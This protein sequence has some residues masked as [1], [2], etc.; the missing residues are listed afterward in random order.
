MDSAS[1]QS[2]ADKKLCSVQA[3]LLGEGRRV[4][5]VDTEVDR[6]GL[7]CSAWIAAAVSDCSSLAITDA[8]KPED[9]EA[10]IFTVVNSG[11]VA[12]NYRI[13]HV[14]IQSRRQEIQPGETQ[15]VGIA[16]NPGAMLLGQATSGAGKAEAML[17][18]CL[19]TYYSIPSQ[20]PRRA[21]QVAEARTA[22][23]AGAGT[24]QG[25]ISRATATVNMRAGPGTGHA[26]L[27]TLRPGDE[28]TVLSV[29]GA[30][31]ECISARQVRFFVSCRYLSGLT[32]RTTAS[33]AAPSV[34]T[35][36]FDARIA[37]REELDWN[38]ERD[39]SCSE[40]Q[41]WYTACVASILRARN[42]NPEALNFVQSLQNNGGGYA[43]KFQEFGLVDLVTVHDPFRE[44]G[45]YI[46]VN[47]NPLI[48]QDDHQL[49]ASDRAT[50]AL[51]AIIARN[52]NAWVQSEY[53][54]FKRHQRTSSGGQRF[55]FLAPFMNC[56]ACSPLVM[57]EYALE[58]SGDGRFQGSRITQVLPPSPQ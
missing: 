49:T 12:K 7:D 28:V 42:A 50:P 24:Q 5:T 18:E 1:I 20:P 54:E 25:T 22:M 9:Q 11:P 30:W 31:C 17:N 34:G 44:S 13:Y 2:V 35:G 3:N 56:R 47:G 33:R 21:V 14:G 55:L 46:L 52:P 39:R 10:V 48:V 51:R 16:F 40:A 58:F 29:N 4:A 26:V 23:P 38:A 41:E 43:S 37:F 8:Q 19:N 27:G 15:Q 36:S 57:I 45:Y 32:T 6:R 53:S